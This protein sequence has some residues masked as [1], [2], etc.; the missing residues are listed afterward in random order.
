ME[1]AE[2]EKRKE[3]HG[4]ARNQGKGLT[5]GMNERWKRRG[6]QES[7]PGNPEMRPKALGAGHPTALLAKQ[8]LGS[9]QSEP[10]KNEPLP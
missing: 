9:P 1:E 4:E 8:A 6:S 5:W 7:L 3:R 10:R 2:A